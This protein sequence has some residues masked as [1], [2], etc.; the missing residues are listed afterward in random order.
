ML[1]NWDSIKAH[2][3]GRRKQSTSVNYLCCLF[4]RK[5]NHFT[6][7]G[8]RKNLESNFG[9]RKSRDN[10][11]TWIYW[12]FDNILTMMDIQEFDANFPSLWVLQMRNSNLIV[13]QICVQL[14]KKVFAS[15]RGWYL[16]QEG[17]YTSCIQP[18]ELGFCSTMI[19]LK[20]QVNAYHRDKRMDWKADELA[21]HF[22]LG[23]TSSIQ[24]FFFCICGFFNQLNTIA[25]QFKLA[26]KQLFA[27]HQI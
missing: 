24:S 21:Q 12:P 5:A 4:I 25:Q 2:R 15:R 10:I 11:L 26:I 9:K 16:V 6:I 3:T 19:T 22:K 1:P 13:F 23:K 20:H 7:H 14:S 27:Q 8:V 17:D 18:I